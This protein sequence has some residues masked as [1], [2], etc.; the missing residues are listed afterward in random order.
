VLCNAEKKKIEKEGYKWYIP[1]RSSPRFQVGW[2][3]RCLPPPRYDGKERK[4]T[5]PTGQ[6][7]DLTNVGTMRRHLRWVY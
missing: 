6:W 4:T 1:E 7:Q 2:D 3:P 5:L